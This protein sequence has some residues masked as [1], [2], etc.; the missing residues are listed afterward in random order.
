MDYE[1]R[2][3]RHLEALHEE[4]RYRVFADLK[5]RCGAY[6]A[7]DQFTGKGT[8]DVTVWCSNDYLGMGQHPKVIGAMVETAAR[9]CRAESGFIFR[10]RDGKVTEHWHQLDQMGMMKQLGAMP[11]Q[12]AASATRRGS[13]PP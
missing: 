12:P 6:P 13:P 8:R 9:I 4:G 1:S 10:L 3:R 5:R 2:F 7:A 11:G